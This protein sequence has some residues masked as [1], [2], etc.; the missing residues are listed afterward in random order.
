MSKKK[1]KRDNPRRQRWG[2]SLG[3][4]SGVKQPYVTRLRSGVRGAGPYLKRNRAVVKACLIFAVCILFFMLAY[5]WLTESTLF[6]GIVT[7]TAR[8]TAF[9]LGLFDGEVQVLGTMVASPGFTMGIIEACTGIVPMIIFVSAVLAYPSSVR[10]KAIGI[11]LG[12]SGIYA[13]NLVRTTTLFAVG[14]H[15][16]GFFDT[17]HY[18]VWQSL[19]ILAAVVFWL[20]WVMRLAHV[21]QK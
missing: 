17:A 9:V 8:A 19:M 20:L 10:Q 14:A 21:A 12:I 16:P 2:L 1:R 18:L 4:R 15:F 6:D 7:F 11:G 3:T 13:V 5:S